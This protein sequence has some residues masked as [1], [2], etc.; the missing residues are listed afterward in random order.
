MVRPLNYSSPGALHRLSGLRLL[1]HSSD[2]KPVIVLRVMVGHFVF[3]VT[4]PGFSSR[5]NPFATGNH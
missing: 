2:V 4:F 1:T 3:L 5:V